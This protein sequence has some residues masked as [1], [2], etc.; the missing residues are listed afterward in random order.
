MLLNGYAKLYDFG[1]SRIPEDEN[2]LSTYI[3]GC[4]RFQAPELLR[5]EDALCPKLGMRKCDIFSY[6]RVLYEVCGSRL[7]FLRMHLMYIITVFNGR[8]SLQLCKGRGYG[9]ELGSGA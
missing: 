1:I 7:R 6:G 3:H 8:Y 4:C 9:K 5:V 2:G